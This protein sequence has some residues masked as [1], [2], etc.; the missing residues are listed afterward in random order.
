MPHRDE[1]IIEPQALNTL[2]EADLPFRGPARQRLVKAF[3]ESA[4]QRR[5]TQS[6]INRMASLG[7]E[8]FANAIESELKSTLENN[9]IEEREE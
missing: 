9:L 6:V 7:A 2:K 8:P 5:T 1:P 3:T 4:R